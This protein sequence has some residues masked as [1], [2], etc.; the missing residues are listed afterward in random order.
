MILALALTLYA[1]ALLP[2]RRRPRRPPDLAQNQD[3]VPLPIA[4]FVPPSEDTMPVSFIVPDVRTDFDIRRD[5]AHALYLDL[6]QHPD[7]S[8][9]TPS[10]D[11]PSDSTYLTLLE[12][13]WLH[14]TR[15]PVDAELQSLALCMADA[16]LDLRFDADGVR[17][18]TW[19][20]ITP[21][22]LDARL[23]RMDYPAADDH[24]LDRAVWVTLNFSFQHAMDDQ[25]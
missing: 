3:D 20:A 4:P 19:I 24:I 25:H 8:M 13:T 17:R 9:V 15:P 6:R 7:E 1:L 22:A 10:N 12:G 16:I 5:L 11:E 18:G 2:M 23:R 21:A 14:L